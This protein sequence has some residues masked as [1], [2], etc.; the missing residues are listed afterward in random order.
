MAKL[1]DQQQLSAGVQE[2]EEHLRRVRADDWTV[3]CQLAKPWNDP[4]PPSSRG[5]P[6]SRRAQCEGGRA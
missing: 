4:P 5:G 2:F 6:K 3:D 1:F